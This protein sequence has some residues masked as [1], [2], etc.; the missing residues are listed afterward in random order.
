MHW[1]CV[2]FKKMKTE[3]CKIR[4]LYHLLN[5]LGKPPL[6]ASTMRIFEFLTC[7]ETKAI[8]QNKI[9]E[10]K[11]SY[12]RVHVQH[13]Y[14]FEHAILLNMDFAQFRSVVFK[15]LFFFFSLQQQKVCVLISLITSIHLFLRYPKVSI[16]FI[17]FESQVDIYHFQCWVKV[18]DVKQSLM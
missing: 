11:V 12:L 17:I 15:N 4:K 9:Q 1:L 10:K 16:V 2:T 5:F 13:N 14:W 18:Q 8:Y 7:H 3:K 6:T